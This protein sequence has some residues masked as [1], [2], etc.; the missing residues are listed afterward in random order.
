MTRFLSALVLAVVLALPVIFGPPWVFF[1]VV[2]IILPM[3][4]FELMRACLTPTARLLGWIVF[5]GSL[6]FLWFTW[7]GQGTAA[8]FTLTALALFIIALGLVLFE[9]GLASAREVAL[10]LSGL[11]YPL[12]LLSF[13]LSLR[14]SVDGRFWMVFGLVCTFISDTGAYYIGK[15]FGRHR[16]APRLSPKKTWEGFFGG[17]ASA[18]LAGI[19]YFLVY[20]LCEPLYGHYALWMI[21][22]LS[23]TVAVLDLIGDL[24]ASMFKREFDIKDLG[25]LIPGHGGMLDRMD[26]IVPVGA[27]LYIIIQVLT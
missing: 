8:Y 7:Q 12:L 21:V 16:L 17:C 10:A 22:I 6:P 20:P 15:N 24:T 25:T 5:Y 13:W 3:C 4:I 11:I 19:V 1:I 9:R 23:L 2:L 18:S 26:G 14:M 27:A